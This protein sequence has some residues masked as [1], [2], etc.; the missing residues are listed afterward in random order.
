MKIIIFLLVALTVS[1]T[2]AESPA[3]ASA[4][5]GDFIMT[6]VAAGSGNRAPV[7]MTTI[8][9]IKTGEVYVVYGGDRVP[10]YHRRALKDFE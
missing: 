5:G 3:S 9:N 8:L 7:A 1:V 2:W 10:T 6:S 4:S